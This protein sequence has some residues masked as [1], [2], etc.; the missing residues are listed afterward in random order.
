MLSGL[1]FIPRDNIDEVSVMVDDLSSIY[2]AFAACVH[3]INSY[4]NIMMIK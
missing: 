1:K 3:S 2:W 4:H